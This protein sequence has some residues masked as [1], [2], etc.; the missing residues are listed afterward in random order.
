M[1]GVHSCY[2]ITNYNISQDD[3]ISKISVDRNTYRY[4][5]THR[6]GCWRRRP[7]CF[8]KR[9]PTMIVFLCPRLSLGQKQKKNRQTAEWW[10]LIDGGDETTRFFFHDDDDIGRFY[11]GVLYDTFCTLYIRMGL[12]YVFVC[13]CVLYSNRARRRPLVQEKELAIYTTRAV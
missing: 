8:S 9:N 7:V 10:N 1:C 4:I 6:R 2:Y 11:I 5:C 3:E 12:L 13:M